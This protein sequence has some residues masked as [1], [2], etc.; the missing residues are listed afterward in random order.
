LRD[1][2]GVLCE[3]LILI[4][5]ETNKALRILFDAFHAP[6][7]RGIAKNNQKSRGAEQIYL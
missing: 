5:P 4:T 6:A 1:E 3:W 2:T 7:R